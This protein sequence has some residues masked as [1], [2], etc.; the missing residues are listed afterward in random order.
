MSGTE[1]NWCN[2]L[3]YHRTATCTEPPGHG[4][5]HS[6]AEPSLHPYVTGDRQRPEDGCRWCGYLEAA[7]P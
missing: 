3:N 5:R 6:W 2:E 7:H 1:C 4:G